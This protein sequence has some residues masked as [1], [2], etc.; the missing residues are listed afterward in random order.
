[1]AGAVSSS[2]TTGADTT[3]GAGAGRAE[4]Q[5]PVGVGVL[6][7]RY[8]VLEVEGDDERRSTLALS[9]PLAHRRVGVS[10]TLITPRTWQ[11]EHVQPLHTAVTACLIERLPEWS[12]TSDHF[13]PLVRPLE[14]FP[15]DYG[16]LGIVS[17]GRNRVVGSGRQPLDSDHSD[18]STAV[19]RRRPQNNSQQFVE[20]RNRWAINSRG[21]QRASED[22]IRPA[23][24]PSRAARDGRRCL[25]SL[26]ARRQG[27]A[28]SRA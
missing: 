5:L 6:H 26:C 23:A 13:R 19:P 25:G 10:S 3:G 17:S 15:N 8:A 28:P 9:N 12:F 14:L 16:L 1:M 20:S 24:R 7:P 22:S 21:R 11:C 4:R 18:H 2:T 27:A